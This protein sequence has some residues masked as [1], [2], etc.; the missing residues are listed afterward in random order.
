MHLKIYVSLYLFL[1][2]LGFH[3]VYHEMLMCH[4][5]NHYLFKYLDKYEEFVIVYA[6]KILQF[7]HIVI[8]DILYKGVFSKSFSTNII[9][10]GWTFPDI[11]GDLYSR[12][13][14]KTHQNLYN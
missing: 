7:S 12:H 13:R 11:C 6:Q 8:F 2:L 4:H 10:F 1:H 9:K 3:D 5:L 14:F